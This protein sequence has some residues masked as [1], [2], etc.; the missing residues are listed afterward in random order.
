MNNSERWP[1]KASGLALLLGLFISAPVAAQPIPDVRDQHLTVLFGFLT[2]D[3]S[4]LH[5]ED[6]VPN[7]VFTAEDRTLV[8]QWVGAGKISVRGSSASNRG[9]IVSPRARMIVLF[10]GPLTRS[11]KLPEPDASNVVYVQEGDAFSHYPSD[12]GALNRFVE[13]TPFS[14]DRI[15]F[16]IEHATIGR[17]GGSVSLPL[18][19]VAGPPS[20]STQPSRLG[21][22][23]VTPRRLE[24]TAPVYPAQ[25][26]AAGIE[27][28]VILEIVVDAAGRVSEA[29]VLRSLPML[30]QPAIDCV[31]QWQY[32]PALLDGVAVPVRMTEIVKFH[33][34]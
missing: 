21:G 12:I 32:A 7:A 18:G 10:T 23:I 4:A 1:I 15:S 3:A 8:E 33:I 17:T 20:R 29:Q 5:I 13:F 2:P 34:H 9:G 22:N 26:I 11:V 16:S 25:A 6:F 30:D 28:D 14:Q 24:D 19:G 31:R 27:G